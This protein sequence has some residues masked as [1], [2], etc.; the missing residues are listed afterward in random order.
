MRISDWSS[1]LCSSD[2]T[3][4]HYRGV[5]R[6][7]AVHEHGVSFAR[8]L[9]VADSVRE[10]VQPSRVIRRER[11]LAE[12]VEPTGEPVG[13][14]HRR[15]RPIRAHMRD[16]VRVLVPDGSGPHPVVRGSVVHRDPAGMSEAVDGPSTRQVTPDTGLPTAPRS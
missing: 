15:D 9:S 6:L 1:D 8:S 12:V 11:L 14:W 4:G 2:L 5:L 3:T 7:P 10:A 13:P 16:A